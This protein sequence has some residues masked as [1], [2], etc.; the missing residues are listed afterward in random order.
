MDEHATDIVKAIPYILTAGSVLISSLFAGVIYF[1]KKDRG[2]IDSD[3]VALQ[4]RAD[5]DIA[6]LQKA[7]CSKIDATHHVAENAMHKAETIEKN[8]ML[9]FER[10][11]DH[12][13]T[14][15]L[16]MQEQFSYLKLHIAKSYPT[17]TEMSDAIKRESDRNKH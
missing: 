2:K 9:R 3:I 10:V 4:Q 6:A 15:Q 12:L 7:V 5:D 8:Y 17:K 1:I 14:M 11:H 16:Q 13:S